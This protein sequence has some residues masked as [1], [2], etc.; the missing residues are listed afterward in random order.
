VVDVGARLRVVAARLVE[1]VDREGEV[2]SV[3]VDRVAAVVEEAGSGRG[4]AGAELPAPFELPAPPAGG[5]RT[6]R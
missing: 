1:V 4:P 2:V 6:W 5:G 3:D